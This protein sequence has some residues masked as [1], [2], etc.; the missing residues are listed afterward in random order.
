MEILYTAHATA[1]GGGREYGHS[2]TDDGKV[3]VKL[4]T[5]KEMGGSGGEGTNPEQLFA[6]GYS[7]CFLG[8][9][10]FAAGQAKVNLPAETT[11]NTQVGFG[12]RD[13]GRGS[14][15]RSSS[16]P[17]LRPRYRNAQG[18]HGSGPHR[19]PLFPRHARQY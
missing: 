8:A 12:K 16:R 3:D 5:P 19:L 11:V 9:M 10:R 15:S 7:A 17:P 2:K 6:T 18:C 14:G 13:D 4:S 1:S